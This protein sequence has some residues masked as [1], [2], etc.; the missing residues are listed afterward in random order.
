MDSSG[1]CTALEK[2][3][4]VLDIDGTLVTSSFNK[5]KNADFFFEYDEYG[6][7]STVGVR[8]RPGVDAFLARSTE[9]FDV[10]FF[11]AAMID[12]AK[13]IINKL[14]P[15]Y[16]GKILDRL[17]CTL[18]GGKLGKDLRKVSKDMA[19]VI[20]VD[21]NKSSFTPQPLNGILVSSW[22]GSTSDDELLTQ[23]LP[24]L[25]ECAIAVDVRK[26]ISGSKQMTDQNSNRS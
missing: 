10:Y 5:T 23:V 25:E 3:I 22:D 11:T 20:L 8:K 16:P 6:V 14:L 18:H 19:S 7:T 17:D 13:P 21:D 4:L 9:L 26:V 12:Y 24:L 1:D 2:K 15:N